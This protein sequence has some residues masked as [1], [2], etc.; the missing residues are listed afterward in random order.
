MVEGFKV[1]QDILIHL[2]GYANFV[3]SR[4]ENRHITIS[5]T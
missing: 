4:R 1:G 2:W 5:D 3:P